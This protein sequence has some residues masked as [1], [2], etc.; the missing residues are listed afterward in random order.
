MSGNSEQIQQEILDLLAERKTGATSLDIYTTTGRARRTIYRY[1]QRLLE[2]GAVG[3]YPIT[4]AVTSVWFLEQNRDEA[5]A[6]YIAGRAKVKE[7]RLARNR[8]AQE[9]KRRARGAPIHKVLPQPEGPRRSHQKK[10]YE[11]VEVTF[12]PLPVNSVWQL[13]QSL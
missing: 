7:A 13:A 4:G 1:S 3:V 5:V 12:W 8:A 11:P 9:R 2:S 6:A 10:D